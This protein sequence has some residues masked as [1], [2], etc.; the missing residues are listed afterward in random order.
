MHHLATMHSATERQNGQ[1]DR[2]Q[3]HANSWTY[4]LAVRLVKTTTLN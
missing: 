2:Q 1:T 3:Y 4:S